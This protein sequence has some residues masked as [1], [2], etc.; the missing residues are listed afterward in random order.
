MQSLSFK[1][2]HVSGKDIFQD[3]IEVDA[4]EKIIGRFCSQIA[5]RLM[6]KHRVD[7][8]PYLECGDKIIIVNAEK[9]KFASNK[10]ENKKYIRH[11]GYPG[12]QRISTPSS[13]APEIVMKKAIKGMLPKNKLGAKILRNVY[14][15]K[16]STHNMEAQKPVKVIIE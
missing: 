5:N 11:T 3:W 10:F 1:T 12:G 6:G 15:F 8:A 4:S 14:V 13:L 2:K 16:S 9:A 7:Y